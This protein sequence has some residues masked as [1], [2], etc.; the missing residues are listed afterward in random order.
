MKFPELKSL[1]VLLCLIVIVPVFSS[2]YSNTNQEE[3]NK[4]IDAWHHAAAVGDSATFFGLM[5]EDAVYL[6]TDLS[7]RWD[8]TS[9]ARDLGKY[10]RGRKAWHFEPFD[11]HYYDLKDKNKVMFDESLKTWMGPCRATG[12]LARVNGKWRIAYYN[13]SVAVPN[14]YIKEYIKLLPSEEVLT[15]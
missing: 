9:M 6:G 15:N 5:T 10:F 13:L 12:V 2:Y 1:L 4:V 7:E 11:R 8:R 3:Q 14:Q